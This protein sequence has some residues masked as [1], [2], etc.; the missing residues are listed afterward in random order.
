MRAQIALDSIRSSNN[1]GEELDGLPKAVIRLGAAKAQESL[2]GRAET[3]PSQAGDAEMIVGAFQ[4]EHGQAM[5]GDSQVT[6]DLRNVRKDV[7][8]AGGHQDFHIFHA[9]KFFNQ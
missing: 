5:G 2:A 9:P 3:F 6:A 1:V 7:K 4:Q 8:R